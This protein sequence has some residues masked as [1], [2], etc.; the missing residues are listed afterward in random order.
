MLTEAEL[1]LWGAHW[2]RTFAAV[3]GFKEEAEWKPTANDFTPTP[4]SITPNGLPSPTA[5]DHKNDPP[6][7]LEPHPWVQDRNIVGYPTAAEL[8]KRL[9]VVEREQERKKRHRHKQTGTGSGSYDKMSDY[10]LDCI[11]SDGSSEWSRSGSGSTTPAILDSKLIQDERSL[12]ESRLVESQSHLSPEWFDTLK[13]EDMGPLDH[14]SNLESDGWQ[15]SRDSTTPAIPGSPVSEP[16][17]AQRTALESL[18]NNSPSQSLDKSS[19]TST[20]ESTKTVKRKLDSSPSTQLKK[21]K[22]CASDGPESPTALLGEA[23]CSTASPSAAAPPAS[24]LIGT[25]AR[26]AGMEVRR[27]SKKSSKSKRKRTVKSGASI[28]QISNGDGLIE[29][30]HC[31][32]ANEVMATPDHQSPAESNSKTSISRPQ[33]IEASCPKSNTEPLSPLEDLNSDLIDG[34]GSVDVVDHALNEVLPEADSE[35]LKWKEEEKTGSSSQHPVHR[36]TMD[37]RR[38]PKVSRHGR[39]KQKQTVQVVIYQP[40]ARPG[41]SKDHSPNMNNPN[42]IQ[43]PKQQNSPARSTRSKTDPD[44]PFVQLNQKGKQS[45]IDQALE[46]KKAEEEAERQR[47]VEARYWRWHKKQEQEKKNMQRVWKEWFDEQD[48]EFER[49]QAARGE[50]VSNFRFYGGYVGGAR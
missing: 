29:Q 14:Y 6:R 24:N 18:L 35:Q 13:A 31:E 37:H 23:A 44:T 5:S 43:K 47:K 22:T 25:L 9:E 30:M 28:S 32:P 12:V 38:S 26:N 20:Q 41:R 1:E 46:E 17:Q 50:V 4:Y 15:D 49:R 27:R 8:V 21:R 40:Y 11:M 19:I 39:D 48:D 2:R 34:D 7:P 10:D 16:T 42:K 36:D 45:Y 33:I 3:G